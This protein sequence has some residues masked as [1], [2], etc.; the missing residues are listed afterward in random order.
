MAAELRVDVPKAHTRRD[1]VPENAEEVVVLLFPGADPNK[2]TAATIIIGAA[3]MGSSVGGI[4]ARTPP[5][6]FHGDFLKYCKFLPVFTAIGLLEVLAGLYLRSSPAKHK[7]FA[8]VVL[9]V[10]V[11]ALIVTSSYTGF[12]FLM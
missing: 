4:F 5:G 11:P 9:F 7:R 12:K 8:A 10:S 6:I 2:I 1:H 3:T